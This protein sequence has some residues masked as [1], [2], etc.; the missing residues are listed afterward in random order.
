MPGMSQ[1]SIDLTNA[2]V[3]AMFRHSLFVTGLIWLAVIAIVLMVSLVAT[4]RILK[5]QY[6]QRRGR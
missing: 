1:Q 4:R 5:I 2:L 3:V 6:V